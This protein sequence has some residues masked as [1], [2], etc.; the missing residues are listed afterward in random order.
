[1]RLSGLI[2]LALLLFISN[3]P[4]FSN[5]SVS[6]TRQGNLVEIA[7][8][9]NRYR[10]EICTP[11]MIRV[12]LSKNG[13]FEADENLMVKQY[14]WPETEFRFTETES[15]YHIETAILNVVIS[16]H[17]IKLEFL[18][19]H[20]RLV[21]KDFPDTDKSMGYIDKKPGCI[22]E[23]LPGEHFF[24]FGERMD[25]IDQLGKKVVLDVGRGVGRPHEVGAYNILEAN[26]SPVP[27]FMSTN[28]YGIFFHNSFKT[29]WD[30]GYS[31]SGQ[32]KF[33]AE[34]GELDY[35]FIFGPAFT[36]I[37]EQYTALTGTSP[38]MPRFAMG[39]HV[40]TYSGGTWGY[41][42]LTSQLY[43]IQLA[44]KFR[45]L[46]IPADIL[47]LDSTWRIFGKI[48]GKGGTSFEWRQPGFP[49]P[50]AMFD[51]L[52]AMNFNMAGLH[53]RPR[54]DNGDINNYLDQAHEL[55]YT[56]PENGKPGDFLNYFDSTSVDWWWQNCLKPLADLGCM[57]VKTDEGSA[58][59]RIGN[60]I[61]KTGPQGEEIQRLHNLFP[62]AYAKAP[63]EKFAENNNMR[64]LNHTREGYAGIQ[65]YPFIFAG[66][67]PSEWQYFLPVIRAGINISMS[68]I[69][70]WTHCMGGFEHIADPELYI[71]W[72]QFGMFSPIAMLFGMEHPN[73]K[74][75]WSYGDEAL[76][77]FTRYDKLRYSLIP[78]IYSSYYQMHKTGLPVMQAL[79][80]KYPNDPNTYTIDDQYFFGNDMLVCPVTV[81]SAKTRTL[82]LPLGEWYDYWTGEKIEGG[83][84]LNVTT[85]VEKMPIFARAGAIIPM[86]LEMNYVGE[87]DLSTIILDIFPGNGSFTL[88]DDDGLSHDYLE[89]KY[90]LT[91]IS[92]H[93]ADN[94]LN[95]NIPNPEGDFALPE[96]DFILKIRSSSRPKV[97]TINDKTIISATQ[98]LDVQ[99]IHPVQ[100]NTWWY[101]ETEKI[102]L[103]VCKQKHKESLRI[104]V[105]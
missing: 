53:I 18:D 52:Y 34:G 5:D 87:K 98:A 80:L 24:G 78:Y 83:R 22:K 77:I 58:F 38:L 73:Y 29:T 12:R 90:A 19:K 8:G 81:K 63:F 72:C 35:Y 2:N 62:I 100:P 1:M 102:L 96:R 89:G 46:G 15:S 75:P 94:S 49:N 51:S 26:Y 57:F 92:G 47:H 69:G 70:A 84:Y 45:E 39:L 40:G 103:V 67:W 104:L 20:G 3:V 91:E 36:D 68:G 95:I 48:N 28:G 33:M 79:V 56:Y 10:L 16:K 13:V 97:V 66:D 11:G 50:K 54:I 88:Y 93:M 23:L 76:K 85:P 64:G 21:H 44:R 99:N 101:N 6:Y 55:G 30:M 25:F 105:E 41:E 17:D 43:V 14:L 31:A 32:Y 7:S 71:R 59:G 4:A 42:H 61:A 86:Q 60:E 74:E 27:F 9:S 65:R 82:Y 37:L